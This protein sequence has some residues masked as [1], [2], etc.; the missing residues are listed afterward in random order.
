MKKD[1][2][3]LKKDLY[4]SAKTTPELSCTFP[5]ELQYRSFSNIYR[6][7][8]IHIDL[9]RYAQVSFRIPGSLVGHF[10]TM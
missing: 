8:F 6:S 9:I 10:C 2:Y 1:L 7:R 5:S 4:C 3:I